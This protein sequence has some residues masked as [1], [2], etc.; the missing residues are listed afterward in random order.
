MAFFLRASNEMGSVLQ[1]FNEGLF[2][3]TVAL[4]DLAMR[5]SYAAARGA[6]ETAD[7]PGTIPTI[8]APLGAAA[9]AAMEA[10]PAGHATGFPVRGGS[11]LYPHN[12]ETMIDLAKVD[13]PTRLI[14]AL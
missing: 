2:R 6:V 9:S 11:L 4:A 12:L 10:F 7:V 13:S 3:G 5:G 1:E 8:I 14:L